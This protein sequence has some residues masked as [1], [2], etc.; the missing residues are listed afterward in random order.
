M[1]RNTCRKD[2]RGGLEGVLASLQVL[3]CLAVNVEAGCRGD[4]HQHR[5]QHHD[6]DFP[7]DGEA[8]KLK[9]F[10][11]QQHE[12]FLHQFAAW[13]AMACSI[14]LDSAIMVNKTCRR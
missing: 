4:G 11:L 1:R 12:A 7:G 8:Q 10:F 3:R 14:N 2:L 6:R 5:C 13:P 9:Q